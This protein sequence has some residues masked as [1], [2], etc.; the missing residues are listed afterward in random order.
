MI[1]ALAAGEVDLVLHWA[2]WPETFSFS[3]CEAMASGAYVV[4]RSESGN[5]AEL[6]RST[7][8]GVVLDDDE[9]LMR[10][11]EGDGA[12]MLALAARRRRSAERLHYRMSHMTYAVLGET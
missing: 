9:E 1:Q 12:V 5:V 11:F 3:T 7:G 2:N 8:R 6:V 10:F 4:T